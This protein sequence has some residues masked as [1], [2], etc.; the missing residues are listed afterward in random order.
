M[1]L[2]VF[3]GSLS[4]F[5]QEGPQDVHQKVSQSITTESKAQDKADAWTTEKERILDEI[6]DMKYN[7]TWHQYRQEK[8]KIY[9]KEAEENIKNLEFQKDEILN[10]RERLDPYLEEV[11]KRLEAFIAEDLPFL[12]EERQRRLDN[13][14]SSL[15][16]YNV[17][18]SEKLRRV[19]EEGLL[20]E[21]QYYGQ[22]IEAIEDQTLNIGGN[23]TQVTL[24]RLGRLLML[25][26]TIDGSQIGR[27]NPDTRQWESLPENLTRN[28]R[29]I[30]DIAQKRRTAEI[31]E[32]PLGVVK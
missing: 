23:D 26:M 10:L 5:G 16:N 9:I 31:V 2:F 24:F 28:V 4:V 3:L 14:W 25:Y 32:L 13:L 1:T 27:Y 11:V 17:T 22:G 7:I 29:R 30:L 6:R 20:I 21:T 19:L 15:N 8:Y 18:L 12:S